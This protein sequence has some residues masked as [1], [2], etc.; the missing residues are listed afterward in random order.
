M[1]GMLVI[2]TGENGPKSHTAPVICQVAW[3]TQELRSPFFTG[4]P[5]AATPS[6]TVQPAEM[7]AAVASGTTAG[8]RPAVTNGREGFKQACDR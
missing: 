1:V 2:G 5:W 6:S 8:T 3:G 4:S 7:T